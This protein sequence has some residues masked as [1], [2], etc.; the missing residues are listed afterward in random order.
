MVAPTRHLHIMSELCFE[1]LDEFELATQMKQRNRE[2]HLGPPFTA[3]IR[4]TVGTPAIV[5]TTAK[6]IGF[7]GETIGD[8]LAHYG[9]LV[10][11]ADDDLLNGWKRVQS[12]WR[13][14][15]EGQPWLTID[16]SCTQLARAIPA[17][18]RDDRHTDE[19]RSPHPALTAL[20]YGAMSR[21]APDTVPVHVH[22]PE[23]TPGYYLQR[24]I[25]DGA[26]AR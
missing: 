1:Q 3:R 20:R 6:K 23:G 25:R 18:L 11:P 2:L 5:S 4:Y 9:V 8:R 14:D 26:R 19:V 17:G 13:L 16:P 24:G 21:P 12:L 15:P 7:R 22:Y 10:I